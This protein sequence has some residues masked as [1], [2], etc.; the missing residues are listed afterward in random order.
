M[1]A[2]ICVSV[3][4]GLQAI[5]LCVLMWYILHAPTW[6][7]T[8]DTDALAQKGGQLKE[9]GEPR[10]DLTQISGVVGVDLAQH[11]VNASSVR[12]STAHDTSTQSRPIHLSL[13]GEGLIMR[14]AMKRMGTDSTVVY[15]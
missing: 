14:S 2:I 1:T 8:L 4:I 13:G 12:L 5:G 10:P 11:D 3:L 6:T 7:G 15:S 9:W